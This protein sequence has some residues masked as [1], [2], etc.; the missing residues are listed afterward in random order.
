MTYRRDVRANNMLDKSK[1][2][3]GLP[4]A[5]PT[6][7]VRTMYAKLGFV[8]RFEIKRQNFFIYLPRKILHFVRG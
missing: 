5:A 2:E 8:E 6:E 1:F 3:N 7:W 4:M